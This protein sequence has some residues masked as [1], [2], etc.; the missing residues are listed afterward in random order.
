MVRLA[1]GLPLL[2][3]QYSS[4][5]LEQFGFP[6]PGLP[7]VAGNPQPANQNTNNWINAAAFTAPAPYTYGNEP[8]HMTQLRE[9]AT[10]NLDLSVAKNFGPERFR[11]Q[12][13]GEFLNLFNH[14]IYGGEF[15]GGSSGIGN[16]LDCGNLGVVYNTRNAPRNIQVSLRLMF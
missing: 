5:P 8:Q 3:V 13:R 7:N 1:S 2:P 6:G 11:V 14:P 4:N 10:K 15:Y 12:F 16:C 9:A